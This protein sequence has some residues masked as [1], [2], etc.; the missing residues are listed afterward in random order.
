V[1]LPHYPVILCGELRLL[2]S[3]CAGDRCDMVGSDDDRARSRRPGAKDR[4]WSSTGRVHGR[5]LIESSGDP[6]CG[7]HHA[8]GDEESRFVG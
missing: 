4:R 8:Q 2:V 3:W 6:L 5:R 1:V 7:P